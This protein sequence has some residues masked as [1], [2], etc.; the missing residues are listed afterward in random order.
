MLTSQQYSRFAASVVH[1]HGRI[2]NVLMEWPIYRRCNSRAIR[3]EKHCDRSRLR[4]SRIFVSNIP[5]HRG[6]LRHGFPNGAIRRGEQQ[7]AVV[8]FT[9]DPMQ[10]CYLSWISDC[11]YQAHPPFD[12]HRARG[13]IACLTGAFWHAFLSYW[14]CVRSNFSVY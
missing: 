2:V 6:D 7:V 11:I 10:S 1:G 3:A 12:L 4:T 14:A 13:F 9:E 8:I 5:A